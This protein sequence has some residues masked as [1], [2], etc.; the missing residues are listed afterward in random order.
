MTKR[1]SSKT[2]KKSS[3]WIV[4][5]RLWLTICTLKVFTV[6]NVMGATKLNKCIVRRYLDAYTA[7]GILTRRRVVP[8]G[9]EKSYDLFSVNGP[10]SAHPPEILLSSAQ[11]PPPAQQRIWNAIKVLKVFS[12]KDMELVTGASRDMVKQYCCTLRKAGYL[13]LI[14]EGKGHNSHH[15]LSLHRSRNTGPFSPIML[16]PGKVLMDR[17]L[18]KV[19]WT[20][21]EGALWDTP[22]FSRR[23]KL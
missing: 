2:P 23:K 11:R 8:D 16:K 1:K 13:R 10:Q 12:Y 21:T 7:A 19:V 9:K 5:K 6:R 15:L 18:N 20:K 22:G 17:N 14:E 3:T 4:R